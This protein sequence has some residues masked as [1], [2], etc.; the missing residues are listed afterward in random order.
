MVEKQVVQQEALNE[1]AYSL[2]AEPSFCTG[3]G[4]LEAQP[5]DSSEPEVQPQAL[6]QV[7]DENFSYLQIH[8]SPLQ[9]QVALQEV[10]AHYGDSDGGGG[11]V[12]GGDGGEG[13]AEELEKAHSHH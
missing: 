13:E 9:V 2:F 6:V 4:N 7:C 5:R 11:G 12:E 3:N 10:Y 8:L 1:N